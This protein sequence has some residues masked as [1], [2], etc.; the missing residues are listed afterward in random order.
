MELT[1]FIFCPTDNSRSNA[2]CSHPTTIKLSD[3]ILRH[4]ICRCSVDRLWLCGFCDRSI[5]STDQEYESI[6]KWSTRYLPSLGGLGIG[7][8]EGNRGVPCGRGE[9]C[10]K[11]LELELEIDCDAEDARKINHSDGASSLYCNGNFSSQVRP[12]YDRHEIE[13]IGGV[14]K[15]KLVKMVKVGASVSGWGDEKDTEP[16]LAREL[17]GTSRSWCSWCQKVIPSRHD[18]EKTCIETSSL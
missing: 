18:L 14:L 11:A 12:G 17:D 3:N 10:A 9:H 16:F 8:R 2:L 7:I 13:G 5:T 4:N 1:K 15:K 6:W